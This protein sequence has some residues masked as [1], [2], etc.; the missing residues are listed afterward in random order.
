M[1]TDIVTVTPRVLTLPN[2]AKATAIRN[3]QAADGGY[4]PHIGLPEVQRIATA[5]GEHGRNRDRDR[6]LVM[7][8]FDACL[9]V[10]E[11]LGLRPCDLVHDTGGWLVRVFGK[12]SRPGVAA[13]SASL[14]AELQAMAY[15][16]HIAPDAKLFPITRR[17]A[18]QVCESAMHRAGVQKP[19]HVGACHVLRHSGALHRLAATGNPRA[20]QH[21]LRHTTARTTLRYLTTLQ[22]DESLIVQQQVDVWH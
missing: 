16:D 15:R 11:A 12:G 18:F 3:S 21:Q 14:A 9:R 13:I 4:C 22:M 6:L 19:D 17:R 20:V 2:N 5:A 10:S 1:S 7:T 8:L